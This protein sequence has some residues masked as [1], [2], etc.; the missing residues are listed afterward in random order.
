MDSS[1]NGRWKSPIQKFSRL[2]FKQTATNKINVAML[3]AIYLE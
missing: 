3:K 2:R 1:K